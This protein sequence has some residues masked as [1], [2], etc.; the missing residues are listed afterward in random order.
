LYGGETAIANYT[1]TT[2][3]RHDSLLSRRHGDCAAFRQALHDEG[4][5]GLPT[6]EV[7]YNI[8]VPHDLLPAYPIGKPIS[9][10][11][12]RVYLSLFPIPTW[13]N[14]DSPLYR[15]WK[16]NEN[17]WRGEQQ[18]EDLELTM[19]DLQERMC[20]QLTDTN[21]PSPYVHG[22][23]PSPFPQG[24]PRRRQH[25]PTNITMASQP[26]NTRGQF[27][28]AAENQISLT[29]KEITAIQFS[30]ASLTY[31][32]ENV[33]LVPDT[34]HAGA[35]RHKQTM[36][37]LAQKVHTAN[38]GS[39]RNETPSQVMDRLKLTPA[40]RKRQAQESID[41]TEDGGDRVYRAAPKFK[42]EDNPFMTAS[43]K[44]A[45]QTASDKTNPSSL[46]TVVEEKNY[47][48]ETADFIGQFVDRNAAEYYGSDAIQ[49]AKDRNEAIVPETVI[50]VQNMRIP[51]VSLNVANGLIA[52]V[53]TTHAEGIVR[54]VNFIR[55]FDK[56]CLS[57]H[58][59]VRF[60]L[61]AMLR[62]DAD[63]GLVEKVFTAQ[64]QMFDRRA[65]I[66]AWRNKHA[67]N[68]TH[69]HADTLYRRIAGLTDY[70]KEHGI[71]KC[72]ALKLTEV[73]QIVA[74]TTDDTVTSFWGNVLG[75]D[76]R[77]SW[78]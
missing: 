35:K 25:N 69:D 3:T 36:V 47:Y 53:P 77:R 56:D 19:D 65:T 68:I 29:S 41:L 59:P 4:Y 24:T 18:L 32:A 45:Q 63:F 71:V 27:A 1:Y 33:D 40:S 62:M 38:D 48:R 20:E 67:F 16:L 15:G 44:T 78:I 17:T 12:A 2:S 31:L 58:L 49:R 51:V 9:R 74:A 52:Y 55:S 73:D 42:T 66:E 22:P 11:D 75:R 28:R 21:P 23:P 39:P 76:V 6:R 61:V 43:K 5:N 57:D 13:A 72:H 26:G 46:A 50:V 70:V 64:A 54:A 60:V 30:A 7:E 34:W 10:E 37:D 8:Y 14:R